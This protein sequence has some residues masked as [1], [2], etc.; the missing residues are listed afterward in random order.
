M[1]PCHRLR[2]A[3]TMPRTAGIENSLE[4]Q[5]ARGQFTTELAAPLM[6]VQGSFPTVHSRGAGTQAAE[7]PQARAEEHQT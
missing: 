2:R 3:V 6:L 4:E 7:R 1:R 5:P